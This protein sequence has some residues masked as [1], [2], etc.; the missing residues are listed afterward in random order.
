MVTISDVL[1]PEFLLTTS[2]DEIEVCAEPDSIELSWNTDY[3]LFIIESLN[4]DQEWIEISTTTANSTNIVFDPFGSVESKSQTYRVINNKGC[5]SN[6]IE[7]RVECNDVC[8]E[9]TIRC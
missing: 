8:L 3:G 4:D 6:E 5:S 9:R 1:A 2:L 7:V